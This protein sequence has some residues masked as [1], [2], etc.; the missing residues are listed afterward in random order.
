VS[1]KEGQLSERE[2]FKRDLRN[3]IKLRSLVVWSDEWQS[4]LERLVLS[5][6]QL[7]KQDLQRR[8]QRWLEMGS[9]ALNSP[10]WQAELDRLRKPRRG[11]QSE[12]PR[13]LNTD[14]DDITS[15]YWR[16]LLLA[17]RKARGEPAQPLTVPGQTHYRQTKEQQAEARRIYRWLWKHAPG[18]L[19]VVQK[20]VEL[21]ELIRRAGGSA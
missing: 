12:L 19:R 11:K 4:E 8:Q 14:P 10:E 18:L 3:W 6:S 7:S 21:R 1:K 2:R 9:P 17:A 15:E 16:V 13:T 20:D 5:K